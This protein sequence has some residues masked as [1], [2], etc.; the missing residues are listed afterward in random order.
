MSTQLPQVPAIP[1]KL[2]KSCKKKGPLPLL[3]FDIHNNSKKKPKLCAKL[4][5][6]Q[7]Y[8]VVDLNDMIQG[9]IKG[10]YDYV[11]TA[12][13]EKKNIIK[14]EANDVLTTLGK[15]AIETGWVPEL[16]NMR[17]SDSYTP[18]YIDEDSAEI[19]VQ[20]LYTTSIHYA[21]AKYIVETLNGKRAFD[22][23]TICILDN[24]NILSLDIHKLDIDKDST[25]T[26]IKTKL[27]TYHL[28]TVRPN[29]GRYSLSCIMPQMNVSIL[30]N[31]KAIFEAL[32]TRD[33][34][35]FNQIISDL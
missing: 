12:D 29:S 24:V 7:D 31:A 20:S 6:L 4:R 11:D 26:D 30:E 8:G 18:E 19:I 1:K 33:G 34:K 14:K 3:E 17:W 23:V 28:D 10:V 21:G 22:A 35:K 27:H 5:E 25:F 16:S 13:V 32:S 9:V 2:R 15:L